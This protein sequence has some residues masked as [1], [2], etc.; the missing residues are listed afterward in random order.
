M[1]T[2]ATASS[3]RT[4]WLTPGTAFAFASSTDDELAAEGRRNRHDRELHSRR[5]AVDAELRAAVD[6]A[7]GVEAPMR[8]SDQF[9]IGRL[10]ER[11]FLRHRQLRSGIHQLAIAELAAGGLVHDHALLRVTAGRVDVPALSGCTSRA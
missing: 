6:L 8:G 1:A 4:T 9:E 5:P 11:D 10:F 7:G 2:I 3:R